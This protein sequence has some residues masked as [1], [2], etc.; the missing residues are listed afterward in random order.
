MVYNLALQ[1]VQCVEDA[2]EITQDTFVAIYNALDSFKGN[3]KITT[4]IYRIT[5]NKCLDHIRTKK[6]RNSLISWLPGIFYAEKFSPV[7]FDHPGV[8]LENKESYRKLFA[9]INTL[10]F[11]QK[12][13]VILL[14]IEQRPVSDVAEI[15]QISPK[16]IESLFQRAKVNLLK[17]L[18]EAKE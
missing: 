18:Q 10:P 13:V 12:T 2:E 11:N 14:K 1:Y 9:I 15:M 3:S 6:R 8:V 5:I 4:W 17:K 7:N 16:A